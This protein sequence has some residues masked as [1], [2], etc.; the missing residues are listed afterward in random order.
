V[1]VRLARTTK[2][3]QR[4]LTGDLD[5]FQYSPLQWNWLAHP[6]GQSYPDRALPPYRTTLDDG[7]AIILPAYSV[8]VVRTTEAV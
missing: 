6:Q 4:P 2:G 1:T 8:T 5:L 3:A 7:K